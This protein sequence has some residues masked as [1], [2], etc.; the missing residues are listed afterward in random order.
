M[1]FDFGVN[2][3]PATSV[4][5]LQRAVGTSPDGAVGPVTLQA[6]RRAEPRTLIEAFG[7]ARQAHYESLD[8]FRTFG[9]GWTRRVEEIRREALLMAGG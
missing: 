1:V 5:L 3:G 7:K 2:A 6:V 8:G 9:A 4:K